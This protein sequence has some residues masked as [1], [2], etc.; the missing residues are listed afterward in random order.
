[1][2]KL[3]CLALVLVMLAVTM[4]GCGAKN[5]NTYT[6]GICQLMVHDSLDQ[7]TNG[8]KDALTEKITA[9]G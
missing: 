9:A 3:I 5:E 2:K 8:F 6:V 1:M 4:V 7:A